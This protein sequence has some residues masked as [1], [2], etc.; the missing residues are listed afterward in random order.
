MVSLKDY[1]IFKRETSIIPFFYSLTF[2]I[3][4]AIINVELFTKNLPSS[5]KS[6]TLILTAEELYVLIIPR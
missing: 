5:P 6:S 3:H 2:E 1:N 4:R